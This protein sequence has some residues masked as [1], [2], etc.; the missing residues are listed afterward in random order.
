[1]QHPVP[2]RS[3]SRLLHVR[4]DGLSDLRFDA[5]PGLLEPGELLV[6]NDTRVLRARLRGSKDTGGRIEVLIEHITGEREALAQLRASQPPRPGTRLVFGWAH[7]TVIGRAG[8]F[9]QFRFDDPVRAAIDREGELP[10][11]PYITH[12]PDA[13]D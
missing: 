11:P 1:A 2:A 8:E 10:L 13:Q 7:A 12:A 5:L 9:W 3:G 4:R 6:F